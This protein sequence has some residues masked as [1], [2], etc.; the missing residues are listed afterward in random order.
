MFKE[1]NIGTFFRAAF[2]SLL[3]D[4]KGRNWIINEI[5]RAIGLSMRLSTSQLHVTDCE[6][7]R[8]GSSNMP[9]GANFMSGSVLAP[10]KA[11]VVKVLC[12][13]VSC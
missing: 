5:T 7:E 1:T 2:G 13:C 8:R 11:S 6:C 10:T 4:G 3:R 12:A 9:T